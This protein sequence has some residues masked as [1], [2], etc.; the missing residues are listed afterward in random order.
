MTPTLS[1]RRKE[2]SRNTGTW[3]DRTAPKTLCQRHNGQQT[4]KMSLCQTIPHVVSVE[5]VVAG[6]S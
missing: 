2:H 6:Q 3:R 1:Q 5:E 4:Q